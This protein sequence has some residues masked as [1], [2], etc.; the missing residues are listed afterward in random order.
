MNVPLFIEDQ[1]EFRGGYVWSAASQ[2][3]VNGYIQ[4][5]QSG[6]D[7]KAFGD[8]HSLVLLVDSLSVQSALL[9]LVPVEAGK[10]DKAA[11]LVRD[12][13]T[14]ASNLQVAAGDLFFGGQGAAE[15]D[16]LENV[17]NAL[18]GIFLGKE[19]SRLLLG[20]PTG[21]T[22][23]KPDFE[24]EKAKDEY[25]GR[26]QFY[27]I[28]TAVTSSAAYQSMLGKMTISGPETTGV[29]A[30]KDF[31]ALLSVVYLTPFALSMGCER[32]IRPHHQLAEP[33]TDWHRRR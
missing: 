15:G 23:A 14:A 1:P 16:V 28:L 6:Y 5:L 21:G 20:S 22:W 4:L 8:T 24:G 3:I 17:V 7:T 30:R 2:S 13:L 27:K 11:P 29:D 31:G 19:K 32:C 18:A 26:T 33:D 25:T 9:N 12:V 10:R